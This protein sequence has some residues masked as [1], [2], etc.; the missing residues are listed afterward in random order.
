MEA[1]MKRSLFILPLLF[2]IGCEDQKDTKVLSDIFGKW[3]ILEY[4]NYYWELLNEK[5]MDEYVLSLDSSIAGGECFDMTVYSVQYNSS[6]RIKGNAY[7]IKIISNSCPDTGYVDGVFKLDGDSL[8][9][10]YLGQYKCDG[11]YEEIQT[12]VDEPMYKLIKTKIDF[13]PICN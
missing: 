1:K 5:E 9:F 11:S 6:K 2:W 12:I 7:D 13:L 8:S 4:E 3:D 10:Y